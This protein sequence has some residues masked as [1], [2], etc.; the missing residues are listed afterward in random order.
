MKMKKRIVLGT[1]L[2]LMIFG[3][4]AQEPIY[5]TY[6]W[7]ENPEVSAFEIDVNESIIAF[8]EKSINE[9][10]FVEDGLIE[11]FLEH[12]ILWL[13][14]D[15]KIEDHNKVYLPYNSNSELLVNKARVIKKNGD[16]IELDASKIHTAKDEETQ[17]TYKYFAFE[18]VEK[19]SFIEYYYVV[20]RSPKYNGVKKTFQS[21][22]P[23]KNV[24]FDVFAPSNL[25]FKFKSYNGLPEVLNDTLASDR[26]HWQLNV[27]SIVKLEEEEM[28]PYAASKQYIVYKLDSN[29][30]SKVYDI[31]SY[32]DVSKNMYAYL[33][34]EL[35]K[36]EL[37]SVKKLIKESKVAKEKND[38]DKIRRLENY[39]K[40]NFY[41]SEQNTGELEDI[42]TILKNKAVS[43]SGLMKLF[44]ATMRLLEVK[45]E[46]VLTSDRFITKFDADF[47]ANNFLREY[48]LYFPS[49]KKFTALD[50]QDA[51]LGFPPAKLTDNYGL[52]IKEVAIGDYKNGVGKIKYIPSNRGKDNANDMIIDVVFDEE[53]MTLTK[54]H[55]EHSYGGYTARYIHPYLT[56]GNPEK[57]DEMYDLMLKQINENLEITSKKALNNTTEMYGVKPLVLVAETTSSAFVSKAG[58]KYLF[59]VG[60]LIG[61]QSEMYQE[62]K[63]VLPIETDYKRSYDRVITIEVPNDYKVSNLDA[64]NMKNL[65]EEDGEK[66]F[67]FHSYYEMKD[68]ILKIIIN[69]YYNKNI[70]PVSIYEPYRKI[71]NSAA[72]FNKITLVLEKK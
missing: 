4:K 42:V 11:Y 35:D 52:F 5:K 62:K 58:R 25:H 10:A 12:R 29:S 17:R 40:G 64:L 14:S 48:L 56:L 59:K 2:L 43:A 72:D 71:I 44:I 16:V 3:L 65:F 50:K 51:R 66:L 70:V 32:G 53:D 67:G 63:R 27:P 1:M 54:I 57:I 30:A 55:F 28:A 19:G 60:E 69:E 33:F 47:E 13:N 39:I 38:E 6:S 41:I 20:K 22:Y 46:V 68:N 9:F 49:V 26:L 37:S 45:I 24:A 8:K 15:D 18:G 7:E 23:K 61:P 31:S 34:K 21:D 36:K